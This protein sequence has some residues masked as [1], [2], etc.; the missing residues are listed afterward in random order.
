MECW[1]VEVMQRTG[2]PITPLFHHSNT[3]FLKMVS[4][5][6]LAPAITWS[7]AKHVAATLRADGP[8]GCFIRAGETQDTNPGN[9]PAVR[10]DK[11]KTRSTKSGVP[12]EDASRLGFPNRKSKIEIRK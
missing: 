1:S 4:A 8:D 12:I 7:Q 2:H 6:G 3:P 11:F 5:A 10:L 9:S